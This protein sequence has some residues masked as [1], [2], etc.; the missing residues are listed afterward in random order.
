MTERIVELTPLAVEKVLAARAE[1]GH[2]SDHGLRLSVT[3]GGCSGYEYSVK[4]AAQPVEG[5]RVFETGG[6]RVFVA[7]D[8]EELLRGTVLDYVDGLSG[9]GLRFVNPN[10]AHECGCGSSFAA[11]TA[12][13]PGSSGS[14]ARG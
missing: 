5:D 6:I 3:K 4:F 12:D 10:A 1:E 13:A 2:G 14:A 11:G 7:A 8:S 9:A